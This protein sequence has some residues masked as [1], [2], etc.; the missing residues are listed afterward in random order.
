M[1]TP[2]CL[3]SFTTYDFSRNFDTIPE[4]VDIVSANTQ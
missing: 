3:L 1:I 2:A 4:E